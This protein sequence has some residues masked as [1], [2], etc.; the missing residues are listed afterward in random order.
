MIWFN[1]TCAYVKTRSLKA[2]KIF[3]K[4]RKKLRNLFLTNS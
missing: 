4:A 3:D 1:L 2:A